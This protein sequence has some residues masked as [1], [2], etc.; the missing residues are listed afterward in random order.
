M[1][2]LK[3]IKLTV[4]I[5]QVKRAPFHPQDEIITFENIRD[6]F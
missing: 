1:Q 3:L 2:K 6:V 4:Y 5:S